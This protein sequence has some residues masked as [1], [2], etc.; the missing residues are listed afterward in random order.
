VSQAL[1]E[2]G[3]GAEDEEV[4]SNHTDSSQGW[5]ES[6]PPSV[7]PTAAPADATHAKNQPS[8]TLAPRGRAQDDAGNHGNRRK[9]TLCKANPHPVTAALQSSDPVHKPPASAH[10]AV[11]AASA[12]ADIGSHATATANSNELAAALRAHC[13][14]SVALAERERDIESLKDVGE[15]HSP[16]DALTCVSPHSMC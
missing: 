3:A 14:T 16:H 13:N 11:A 7:P 10:A 6:C 8:P 9:F 4:H 12:L 5:S 1:A 2:R 15:C